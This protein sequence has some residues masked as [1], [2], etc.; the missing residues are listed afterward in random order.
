MAYHYGFLRFFLI[1]AAM[2]MTMYDRIKM[3]PL[4]M[5]INE[6]HFERLISH[7]PLEFSSPEDNRE[8]AVQGCREYKLTFLMGGTYEAEWCSNDR[9]YRL[10]ETITDMPHVI[11]PQNL[12]GVKRTYERTYRMAGNGSYI[13][14]SREDFVK[15]MMRVEE[16]RHNYVNMVCNSLRKSS[17][18]LMM[19]MGKTSKEQH[20][21]NMITSRCLTPKGR[22]DV[23]ITMQ[24]I[25]DTTG[26][27]LRSVSGILNSWQDMGLVE[28][29]R[30][31]FVIHDMKKLTALLNN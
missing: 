7:V 20:I 27:T 13:S 6:R 24:T 31:G 10:T 23:N 12:F 1:F 28:L 16:I 9:M 2:D 17:D 29:R 3:L 22:K 26:E 8:I 18:S 30:H 5:G 19:Q 11:E 25:A 14:I 15:D 4:W 21:V